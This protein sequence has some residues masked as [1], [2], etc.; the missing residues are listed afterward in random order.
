M[1]YEAYWSFY[2]ITLL[3]FLQSN[4]NTPFKTSKLSHLFFHSFALFMFLS[5]SQH[6]QTHIID[7]TL[8]TASTQSGFAIYNLR[9]MG[10]AADLQILDTSLATIQWTFDKQQRQKLLCNLLVT[11]SILWKYTTEQLKFWTWKPIRS[12]HCHVTGKFW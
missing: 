10:L 1:A 6:H 7:I 8:L 2:Y 11:G 12:H 9:L 4:S 5:E 3:H